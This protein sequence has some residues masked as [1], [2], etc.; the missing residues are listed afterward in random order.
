MSGAELPLVSILLPTHNR[1]DYA[2][3]ALRSALAQSYPALEI[4]VSDNSDDERT[5]ERLAPYLAQH[6]RLR[7]QRIA[8]CPPLENFQHCYGRADGEYVNF[9]MDDD[10]LHPAKI[11]RMMAVMLDQPGVGVVTSSRQLIDAQGQPIAAPDHLAPLFQVDTHVSG[12]SL[13]AHMAGGAG[14]V[15]GEPTTALYRKAAAGPRFGMY[16]GHQYA[17]LSDMATWL[18]ILREQDCVYLCEPLSYFRIHAE[19]DQRVPRTQLRGHFESLELACDVWQQDYFLPRDQRL[20]QQLS[21]RL[22]QSAML[23]DSAH[24]LLRDPL[25]DHARIADSMQRAAR[26]LLD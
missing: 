22:A 6:P 9:L 19:Q 26:L 5:R 1:P 12:Q 3:Q 20:R 21:E 17:V 16:M 23:L 2:E 25:F 8:S 7:Y 13:G 4:V 15:L 24:D 11:A 18:T 14:N 10:L